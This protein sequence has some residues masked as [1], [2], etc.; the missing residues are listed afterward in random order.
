MS[1]EAVAIALKLIEALSD[2]RT[3][4]RL[5]GSIACWLH[6]PTIRD[7]FDTSYP[8]KRDLDFYSYRCDRLK[9]ISILHK[10]GF[11][12][13]DQETS[14]GV[15]ILRFS[16]SAFSPPLEIH[17]FVGRFNFAHMIPLSKRI[18]LDW[19]TFPIAE[20]L[21]SKLQINSFQEPKDVLDVM[22]LFA[23]HKVGNDDR[24]KIDLSIIAKYCSR[25]WGLWY[26]TRRN[27]NHTYDWILRD[28]FFPSD[29]KERSIRNIEEIKVLLDKS[30]K[31]CSWKKRSLIG[32]RMRWYGH[33]I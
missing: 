21:I 10:V 6:C 18:A 4:V 20:L 8:R 24:E 13:T 27:L 22:M 5:F 28:R 32:T 33:V 16:N 1:T 29:L 3:P 26:D 9:I 17:F 11:R 2:N 30:S 14:S 15:G 12:Y 19:P 25:D 23:E 7:I 31:K